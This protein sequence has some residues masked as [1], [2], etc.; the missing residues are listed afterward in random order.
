MYCVG[1]CQKTKK[2]TNFKKQAFIIL[3]AVPRVCIT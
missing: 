3:R 1:V 2:S